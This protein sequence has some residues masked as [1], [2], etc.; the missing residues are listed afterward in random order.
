MNNDDLCKR[1]IELN[2]K[3]KNY[4]I[5]DYQSKASLERLMIENSD[6]IISKFREVTLDK[7]DAR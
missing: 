3:W 6:I 5:S 7:V 1:M 2:G 4:G